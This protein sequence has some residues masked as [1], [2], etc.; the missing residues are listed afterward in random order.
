MYP[1]AALAGLLATASF[2]LAGCVQMP[3]GP[4]VAVMP[5]ANKPFEVFVQEDQM[6]RGWAASSIGQPGNEAAANQVVAS[7][8]TGAV[9]GGL[10][11][12]AVG[13]HNTA[14]AGAAMGTAIGASAGVNQGAATAW[15]AQR[16]YDIAY[17]QCMYSKGNVVPG[18]RYGAYQYPPPPPPPGP[19]R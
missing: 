12:A 3:M 11:G 18:T 13:N 10:I 1:N 6:C 14:G 5:A 19:Q 8:V 2:L 9:I 17:Q 7:T 15:N 16:R 4:N